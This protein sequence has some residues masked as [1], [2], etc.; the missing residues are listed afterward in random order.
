MRHN[1]RS[2]IFYS[3]IE[4]GR[5]LSV[6]IFVGSLHNKLA[7]TINK[8]LNPE[9]CRRMLNIV[10]IDILPP[11]S[12]D[13]CKVQQGLAITF[14]QDRLIPHV[15][16]SHQGN[17]K[18]PPKLTAAVYTAVR[19]ITEWGPRLRSGDTTVRDE[20]MQRYGDVAVV[21]WI[22]R[23]LTGNWKNPFDE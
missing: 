6:S 21:A 14:K 18:E 8:Q 10:G 9:V 12:F 17:G 2:K 19:L 1:N 13:T 22:M 7:D 23:M 5:R 16:F 11:L 4:R 15:L 20:L 3:S